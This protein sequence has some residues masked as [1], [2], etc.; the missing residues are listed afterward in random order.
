MD[1]NWFIRK[2][3]CILQSSLT[4]EQQASTIVD[5]LILPLRNIDLASDSYLSH[6]ERQYFILQTDVY[7]KMK[8]T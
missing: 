7:G 4:P 1:R 2:V 5:E 8:I 3:T 6:L